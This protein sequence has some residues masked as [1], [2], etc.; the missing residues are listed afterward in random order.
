[1][2]K[3]KN[4][5]PLREYLKDRL[6]NVPVTVIMSLFVAFCIASIIYFIIILITL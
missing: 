5:R 2:T 1:M 6:K 3:V 4:R